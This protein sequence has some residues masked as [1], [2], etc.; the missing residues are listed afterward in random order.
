MEIS[1][2]YFQYYIVFYLTYYL[3]KALKNINLIFDTAA[4]PCYPQ[5]CI[6]TGNNCMPSSLAFGSCEQDVWYIPYHIVFNF[7]F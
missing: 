3:L 1:L 6:F 2:G 7:C 5:I 4:K